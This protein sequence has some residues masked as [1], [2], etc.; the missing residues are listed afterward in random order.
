MKRCP[1]CAEEIQEEAVFCRYCRKKVKTFLF[2]RVLKIVIVLAIMVCIITWWRETREIA[3]DVSGELEDIWKLFKELLRSLKEG[4][5]VFKE[6]KSQSQSIG[7]SAFNF[8][9]Q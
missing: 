8:N 7:L 4:L 3:R 1:Y 5:A 9:Q 2:W 6:Y